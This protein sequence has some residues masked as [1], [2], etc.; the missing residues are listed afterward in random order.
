[1]SDDLVDLIEVGARRLTPAVGTALL[2]LLGQ[3]PPP[4]PPPPPMPRPPPAAGAAT[5]PPLPPLPP[6]PPS[7]AA[8]PDAQ[9]L[10]DRRA[11]CLLRATRLLA[12]AAA[13]AHR[14]RVAVRWQAA[15]PALL[16]PADPAAWAAY[17]AGLPPDR[18]DPARPADHARWRHGW[19]HHRARPLPAAPTTHYYRLRAQAAGLL[20][21]AAALGRA[22][23]PPAVLLR[24]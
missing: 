9:E 10:A 20:A 13:L 19:L 23:S 14:A 21:E 8:P 4:A 2:P 7:A 17:G 11:D 6:L 22:P 18:L 24:P 3:L 5:P 12:Q 16:P 15:L 1:M